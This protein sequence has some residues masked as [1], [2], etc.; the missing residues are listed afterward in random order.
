MEVFFQSRKLLR[1]YEESAKANR[2][3]GSI[4]GRRYIRTVNELRALPAFPD[5]FA[6]V[7]MR[8]HPY[9]S[10]PGSYALDMTGR[11]RLI[12]RQGERP[13]QVVVEEVSNHY[14]D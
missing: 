6:I 7:R 14:D 2:E 9:K 8:A 1:C 13:D 4:V 10:R 3:W 5:L 11:W 12:V